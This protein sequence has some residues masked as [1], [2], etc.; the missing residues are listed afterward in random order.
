[1]GPAIRQPKCVTSA[2]ATSQ[3]PLVNRAEGESFL[4]AA[5]RNPPIH[6]PCICLCAH[7]LY[8]CMSPCKYVR[9]YVQMNVRAMYV[10]CKDEL[11]D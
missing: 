6:M 7:A 1:M 11:I 10:V 2:V 5:Y 8:V 3:E 4:Q 9:T